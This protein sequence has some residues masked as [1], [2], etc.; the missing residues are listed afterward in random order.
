[1]HPTLFLSVTWL[2]YSFLLCCTISS[3]SFFFCSSIAFF[4]D[5]CSSC[6][7]CYLSFS[8]L[9]PSTSFSSSKNVFS[10]SYSMAISTLSITLCILSPLANF[11]RSLSVFS[12]LSKF[13]TSSLAIH[14]RIIL[15]FTQNLISTLATLSFPSYNKLFR[16]ETLKYYFDK[17]RY[18]TPQNSINA[19]LSL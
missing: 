6:S 11:S 5:L 9:S 8:T 17:Y 1:M 12:N 2:K 18:A 7:L 15:I 19:N 13:F 14:F 3:I 16:N 10:P 4:S